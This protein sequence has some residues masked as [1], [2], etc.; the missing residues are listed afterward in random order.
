MYRINYYS[1]INI[2]IYKLRK[3]FLSCALQAEYIPLPL[4]FVCRS[5]NPPRAGIWR[6]DL[7]EVTRCRR[8]NE[9]GASITLASL[10]EGKELRGLPLSAT[11]GPSQ[12]ATHQKDN[13]HQGTELASTLILDC[14]T[15]RTTGNKSLLLNHPLYGS[16]LW[17]PKQTK[18]IQ[19]GTLWC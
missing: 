4:K 14:P 18:I 13:A 7:W 8:G 15:S 19:K 12:K 1:G 17:Q 6:W 3:Y 5:P 2:L 11:W 16:L 10:K 9:G